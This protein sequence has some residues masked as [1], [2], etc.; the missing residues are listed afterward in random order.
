MTPGEGGGRWVQWCPNLGS[1][2]RF[3]QAAETAGRGWG[4]TEVSQT[5]RE[6][7][8]AEEAGALPGSLCLLPS[9][10]LTRAGSPSQGALG[11]VVPRRK[12]SLAVPNPAWLPSPDQTASFRSL[13]QH[14]LSTH[15]RPD[16]ECWGFKQTG[17]N[18]H[19]QEVYVRNVISSLEKH[20]KISI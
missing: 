19:S 3:Q 11:S 15:R 2:V 10:P 17:E 9:C 18:P 12:S 13:H 1:Q 4:G 7:P 6:R 5:Q 8:G 16:T 20:D 14:V